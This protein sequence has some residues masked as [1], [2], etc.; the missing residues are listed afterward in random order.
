MSDSGFAFV[1]AS[2]VAALKSLSPNASKLWIAVRAGRDEA[3]PFDCGARDFRDWGLSKDQTSRALAE[4]VAIGLLELEA[5]S[6]FGE[7]R[8]RA[9]YRIVHRRDGE[10]LQSHQCD[11]APHDSR[12]S[13]TRQA[14]T[15]APARHS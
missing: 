3:K 13:A 4:L 8:R 11:K 2:E 12:T 7:K 10:K 15:V 14:A 5:Q 9:R 1:R 6:S